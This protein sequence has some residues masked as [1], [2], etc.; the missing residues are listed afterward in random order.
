M[1]NGKLIQRQ[2]VLLLHSHKCATREKSDPHS[3]KCSLPHCGE[4]KH[5]LE[6]MAHCSNAHCPFRHC[7][8][9][10]QIITHWQN[11][12]NNECAVCRPLRN[13]YSNMGSQ[14]QTLPQQP[15][16]SVPYAEMSQPSSR[17]QSWNT[18][19][20]TSLDSQH[21][22]PSPA[23]P[24]PRWHLA[25]S[26]AHSSHAAQTLPTNVK[27]NLIQR[28]LVV[29][30]HAH[31]CALREMRKITTP[32]NIPHCATFKAVWQHMSTCTDGAQCT[33]LRCASS[34]QIIAHWKECANDHCAV[35]TALK[36]FA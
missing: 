27:V 33:Y 18:I 17:K 10:R 32:C 20:S 36:R 35:C 16:V 2:L 21:N 23:V 34:R 26:P 30:L 5:L 9:S 19:T 11:C 3:P 13:Y 15:S 6:H 1:D 14:P 31:K 24:S 29:L 7:M 28:Q 4:T 8:T 12:S 25:N 22:S